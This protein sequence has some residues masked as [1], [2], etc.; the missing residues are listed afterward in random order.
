[1]LDQT[2]LA[3]KTK[4]KYEHL[5]RK[6]DAWKNIYSLLSKY[7]LMR[8]IVFGDSNMLGQFPALS[9]A[10]VSSDD[11]ID[12]ARTASTALSGALWPNSSES[13]TLVAHKDIAISSDFDFTY[14]TDVV[15]DYFEEITNR[16]RAAIDSSE[17]RFQIAQAEYFD[18]QVV[19]GT[20]GIYGEENE[21]DD[22]NPF[23]FKS[24][25]IENCV[26][27]EGVGGRIDTV[28][29]EYTYT[30]RQLVDKYG[31]E[32][33]SEKSRQAY[34]AEKVESNIRV[35]QAIEPRPNGKAGNIN[36]EK[37]YASIHLEYQDGHILLE[38]GMDELPVFVTR[39]R[40]RPAE[41]MG[42]SLAMD[43]LP[44]VRE[45]NVLCKAYSLS[46][47]KM[48]NP[49]LGFFS[50]MIGGSGTIDLS[51]GARNPLYDTGRIPQGQMPIINLLQGMQEPQSAN[52]RI[53]RLTES[54]AVKFL[55]D[56]LLDFNNKTRMTLGETNK[57]EDL[58][59]QAL[60]NIFSR[61]LIELF[62]PLVMWSF[63]VMM[64]R[65][66]LG[67]HPQL[68]AV[69]IHLKQALGMTPLVIPDSV[70]QMM[71]NGNIP[72]VIEF[73]SPAARAMK[74]EALRGLDQLTNYAFAWKN[75]GNLDAEDNIDV[76]KAM[77]EYQSM[78]GAPISVIRGS[79]KV[80][81]LRKERKAMQ[82]QM[83]QLQAGEQQSTIQKNN[84][85]AAKD[86]SQAGIAPAQ[87]G[88]MSA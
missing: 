34:D 37:P 32:N 13:F 59:N 69:E 55:V 33:V 50:D 18:D 17:S 88:A 49:P 84:A 66:L 77:R 46:L 38:S 72:F 2:P 64:R 15:K 70:A 25:S 83:G 80:E 67:L 62:Y 19:F 48:L 30:A 75:A 41:L 35:V 53:E 23:R 74:A 42:R 85:K 16:L 76:D 65:K 86:Y 51:M 28:Y 57:R 45:L 58:R 8:P 43:A 1:M 12:A 40:K 6:R 21:L 61:Q 87:P 5:L 36:K 27:D 20:S 79:D 9:V 22:A 29:F 26:I 71:S 60:G 7:I 52:V 3:L 54:I 56:R 82:A 63:K 10:D 73:V 4:A 31:Y 14:E 68:D 11:A 47:G 44:T 78:C 81:K 24:A 39:F